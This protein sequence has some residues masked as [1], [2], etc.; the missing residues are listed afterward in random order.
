MVNAGGIF[1]GGMI[2]A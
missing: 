2:P 1:H